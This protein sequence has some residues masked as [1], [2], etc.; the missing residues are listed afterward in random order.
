LRA[1]GAA[2]LLLSM[3]CAS[4]SGPASGAAVRI[5][6][7]QRGAIGP[8]LREDKIIVGDFSFVTAVAANT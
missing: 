2:L 6:G 4:M 1:A 3:G 7:D 8:Y 5:D